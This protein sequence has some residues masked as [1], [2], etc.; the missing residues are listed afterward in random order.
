MNYTIKTPTVGIM[1]ELYAKG[2]TE[3]EMPFELAQRC[4][5]LD[6]QPITREQLD[7]MEISTFEKLMLEI[8]EKKKS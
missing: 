4:I 2:F 7:E 8:N 6:G 5:L 1:R 3:L